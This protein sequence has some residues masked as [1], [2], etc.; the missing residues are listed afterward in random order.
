MAKA[1]FAPGGEQRFCSTF[2]YPE[3]KNFS[4]PG[5]FSGRRRETDRTAGCAA[6]AVVS[7]ALQNELEEPAT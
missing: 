3:K 7:E 2:L 6:S 4:P 1:I 5:A